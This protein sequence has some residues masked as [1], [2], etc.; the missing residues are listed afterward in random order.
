M[1]LPP[2]ASET[3]RLWDYYEQF[4][5]HV[6]DGFVQ[7]ESGELIY[8][9]AFPDPDDRRVYAKLGVQIVST[10]DASLPKL[11]TP[12]GQPI[13]KSWLNRQGM[14]YLAV[15]LDLKCAVRL[16]RSKTDN[17]ASK[18]VPYFLEGHFNAYWSGPGRMPIGANITTQ[19]PRVL[20]ADDKAHMDSIKAQCEAWMAMTGTTVLGRRIWRDNAPVGW[21]GKTPATAETVLGKTMADISERDR[22]AIAEGS[23]GPS[24]ITKTYNSLG[25]KL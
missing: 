18:K 16:T 21:L 25:V 6:A 10:T 23:Y 7:F 15:D 22:A 13:P 17:E 12:E 9:R 8:T 24:Y 4:H 5:T 1:I 2:F 19:E 11:L 14:Q 20:S 3:R